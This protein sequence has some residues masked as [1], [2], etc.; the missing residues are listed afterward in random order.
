VYR[1]ELAAGLVALGY[2]LEQKQHGEFEIK[3]FTPE[4]LAAS[5]PRRQEIKRYLEEKGVT[6]SEAAEI[7]AHSTREGKLNLNRQDLLELNR[8]LAA[9]YGNS[10]EEVVRRAINVPRESTRI[11]RRRPGKPSPGPETAISNVR[12]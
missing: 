5:R 10:P 11:R 1:S 4:Y 12:P 7:A 3:G 6:G 2:E 9:Q 8:K